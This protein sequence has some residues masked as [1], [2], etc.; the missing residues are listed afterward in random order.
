MTIDLEIA[1]QLLKNKIV[2]KNKAKEIISVCRANK[3]FVLDYIYENN[4]CNASVINKILEELYEIPFIEM[5]MIRPDQKL[6]NKYTYSLLKKHK[7]VPIREYED[8]TL[9]VAVGDVFNFIGLSNVRLGHIG[10]INILQSTDAQIDK[11]ITSLE[12]IEKTTNAL[13]KL[14]SKKDIQDK[15][16]EIHLTDEEEDVLNTPS[17]QLLD[18]IIKEAIA[19]RASDIHIEPND[20]L[21]KVRYRVDGDLIERMKFSIEYYPAICAR[22]KIMSGINIAERRI[23]QDGRINMMVNN[24]EYDFRT[25]TLPTVYGE[26]FVI[27]ILDKNAFNLTRKELGFSDEENKLIDK[28]LEHPHG[29]VLLTGPTG[30]GKSTTLYSFLKDLNKPQVNI[31]TVEDPVEYTLDG[32]NQTQVNSK[33]NMTFAVALR[34]ILRQDPDIIM[35]GEIRDN[36]T[37]Q[38][39]IRAAITGHLVLSTLHTNDAPG[40]IVRLEDMGISN[41][42]VADAL[43]C[44]IS[45]RL[46]KK[47]CPMCKRKTKTTM[48]EMSMLGI[49]SPINIFKAEGCQYC[50]HTGYKGRVAVHEIMYVNDVMR[51]AINNNVTL[52]EL[53]KLATENGMVDLYTACKN[54]VV[55]GVT[56]FAELISLSVE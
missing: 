56:S 40:A 39:A 37:A 32:V 26:K 23:P 17:V 43:V 54:Y 20:K 53:R 29:I 18:S 14:E 33:A 27:R 46:V 25:S 5:D 22:L 50:N 4:I 1:E 36:E 28:T 2:D 47:L 8:G 15:L 45:Q 10:N 51:N 16:K 38:I 24:I 35:I 31:I 19:F 6:I 13:D 30:C 48:G 9:L 42:L 12:A 11:F 21:V 41:Y 44:V 49:T 7:F 3:I 34:S 52:E 55:T